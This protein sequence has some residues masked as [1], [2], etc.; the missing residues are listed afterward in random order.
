[1]GETTLS[2]WRAGR[3]AYKGLLCEPTILG[4]DLPEATTIVF[5]TTTI[6]PDDYQQA[7]ARVVRQG[8]ESV[9]KGVKVKVW[10]IVY[11]GTEEED[12]EHL[13]A[14]LELTKQWCG[15][16]HNLRDQ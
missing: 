2:A 1:M 15:E 14:K 7:L 12:E 4:V 13:G 6:P 10:F 5:V 8:N 3:R 11:S 9:E 16:S